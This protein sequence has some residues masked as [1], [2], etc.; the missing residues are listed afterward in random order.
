[1]KKTNLLITVLLILIAVFAYL[2]FSGSI[3]FFT[4]SVSFNLPNNEKLVVT[5]SEGNLTF[6]PTEKIDSAINQTV[7][8]LDDSLMLLINTKQ[9]SS[10]ADAK[11]L[12]Q[13]AAL[14]VYQPKGDYVSYDNKFRLTTNYAK[15][16]QKDKGGMYARFYKNRM[17]WNAWNDLQDNDQAYWE[18]NKIP[19]SS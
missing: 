11:Y 7:K 19:S 14:D 16:F 1:M 9:D 17:G 3:S 5:D 12:T 6:I 10:L 13:G 15:G 2:Y 8:S 4:Q 18:I